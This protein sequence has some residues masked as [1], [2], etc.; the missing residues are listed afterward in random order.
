MRM[1]RKMDGV[2]VNL[3][4]TEEVKARKDWADNAKRVRP[5]KPAPDRDAA[6]RALIAGDAEAAQAAMDKT[7]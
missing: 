5:K 2:E 3:T 7:K 4:P 6:I 1:T